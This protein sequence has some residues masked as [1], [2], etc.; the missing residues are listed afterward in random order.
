MYDR[1]PNQKTRTPQRGQQITGYVLEKIRALI[2][3]T[4]KPG[5]G[6]LVGRVGESVVISLAD[7]VKGGGKGGGGGVRVYTATT[8][9]GLDEPVSHVSFGRVTD[10]ADK[11]VMYVRNPDNDGWDAFNRLE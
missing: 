6:V 5:P 3:Q 9:A 11:G 2:L 8:K 7:G 4:V 10:G 1:D